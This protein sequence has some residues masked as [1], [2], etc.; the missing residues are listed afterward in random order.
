MAPF[1][2]RATFFLLKLGAPVLYREAMKIFSDR[3]LPKCYARAGWEDFRKSDAPPVLKLS[4]DIINQSDDPVE[5]IR[6]DVAHPGG[7]RIVGD[8]VQLGRHIYA[9][10]ER[11]PLTEHFDIS[12]ELDGKTAKAA[13]PSE[14]SFEPGRREY[15]FYVLPADENDPLYSGTKTRLFSANVASFALSYRHADEMGR[16]RKMTVAAVVPAMQKVAA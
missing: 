14:R 16:I 7:L 8:H 12:E 5:I 10:L 13:N 9:G 11:P 3:R 1:L 4:V 15:T 6:I 2:E